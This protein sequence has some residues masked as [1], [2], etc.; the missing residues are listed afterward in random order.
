MD[1]HPT[2][3][4]TDITRRQLAVGAL[5]VATVPAPPNFSTPENAALMNEF[6]SLGLAASLVSCSVDA[7]RNR[8][9]CYVGPC[10]EL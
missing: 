7:E 4:Q 5:A 9:T 8:L 6:C 10:T 3:A 1:D 2:Y